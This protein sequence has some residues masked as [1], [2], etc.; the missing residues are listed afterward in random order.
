[1]PDVAQSLDDLTVELQT[2]ADLIDRQQGRMDIL[3]RQLEQQGLAMEH[4]A[5]IVDK[6]REEKRAEF[7]V[8]QEAKKPLTAPA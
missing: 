5:R 6:V 4:L 2:L 1:M 3:A 8:G 7:E